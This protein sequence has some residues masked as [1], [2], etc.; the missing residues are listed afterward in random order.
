MVKF[1]R[2]WCP[3]HTEYFVVVTRP[4]GE[5]IEYYNGTVYGERTKHEAQTYAACV[6]ANYPARYGIA[7]VESKHREGCWS[8][9]GTLRI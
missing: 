4:S 5:R 2:E 6:N 3:A 1:K 8:L 7:T 9:S